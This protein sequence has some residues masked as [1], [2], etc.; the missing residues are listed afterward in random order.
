VAPTQHRPLVAVRHP[1][2]DHAGTPEIRPESA[3]WM[4][5]EQPRPC[6]VAGGFVGGRTP[7]FMRMA[8]YIADGVDRDDA[9][10]VVAVWHD[11]SH[12]NMYMAKHAQRFRIL[13]PAYLYP[14]TWDK[15]Y[16]RRIVV[17]RI[18]HDETRYSREAFVGV[19]GAATRGQCRLTGGLGSILFMVAAAIGAAEGL[20]RTHYVVLPLNWCFQKSDS[21]CSDTGV[22]VQ[23]VSYRDSWL[24]GMRRSDSYDDMN[25][26]PVFESDVA[27]ASDW[28]RHHFAARH[29]RWSALVGS[30]QTENK[31]AQIHDKVNLLLVGAF[32]RWDL[33]HPLARDRILESFRMPER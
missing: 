13:P 29:E 26:K 12:L 1:L 2:Q 21:L 9:A 20:S 32:R 4:P 22:S 17:Q 14:D 19:C 24:R 6:Y 28:Q 16:Q 8:Q 5:S 33:F 7:E 10:E 11:E 25:F 23:R 30:N 3:A 15:L 31:N 18:P 27:N